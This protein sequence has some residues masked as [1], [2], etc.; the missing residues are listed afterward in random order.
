[1]GCCSPDGH[2]RRPPGWRAAGHRRARR[3]RRERPD[4]YSVERCLA[5]SI[6]YEPAGQKF[7]Y[8]QFF[9]RDAPSPSTTPYAVH[10][11][12]GTS[13]TEGWPAPMANVFWQAAARTKRSSRW[14]SHRWRKTQGFLSGG[15]VPPSPW[16]CTGCRGRA[17]NVSTKKR[18]DQLRFPR[19]RL[20]V[21]DV[22]P[23]LVPQ[24]QVLGTRSGYSESTSPREPRRPTR[25]RR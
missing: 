22:L 19:R 8:S 20:L 6:S 18:F 13:P 23:S 2:S 14:P 9:C 25:R 1:V 21:L 16:T 7:R 12:G 24:A 17:G 5:S 4:E 3:A 11:D 15:D 10:G